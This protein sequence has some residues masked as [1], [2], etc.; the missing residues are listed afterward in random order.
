[1]YNATVH[2]YLSFI[3]L[4]KKTCSGLTK[5]FQHSFFTFLVFIL[6]W[7]HKLE[8]FIIAVI[9]I[10]S[11]TDKS[12]EFNSIKGPEFFQAFFAIVYVYITVEVSSF[13]LYKMLF[14]CCYFLGKCNCYIQLSSWRSKVGRGCFY[15]TTVIRGRLT[16]ISATIRKDVDCI[17]NY[18]WESL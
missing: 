7:P 1:M 5:I 17:V 2:S 9:I 8:A 6:T 14:K 12:Y 11:I 13:K 4:P 18:S 16:I 10:S 3:F 15:S